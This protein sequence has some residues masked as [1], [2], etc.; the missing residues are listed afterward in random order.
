MI[1]SL[2]LKYFWAQWKR[3]P[4]WD[5]LGVAEIQQHA[6]LQAF[7]GTSIEILLGLQRHQR[8]QIPAAHQWL[9]LTDAPLI[10]C[11]FLT[12]IFLHTTLSEKKKI[13]FSHILFNRRVI[14]MI[15]MSCF[16][17]FHKAGDSF[18]LFISRKSPLSNLI[19][20]KVKWLSE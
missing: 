4:S 8:L 16:Q 12:K 19:C 14:F 11:I 17:S 5:W 3:F 7:G 9:F 18:T 20:L 6:W 1:W 13:W 2:V 15:F 10:R